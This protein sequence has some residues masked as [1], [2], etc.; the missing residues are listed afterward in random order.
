MVTKFDVGDTVYL[1]ASVIGISIDDKSRILYRV[2]L[3]YEGTIHELFAEQK[4]LYY[5]DRKM[6]GESCKHWQ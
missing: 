5:D 4:D 2:R 6:E 3:P 1:K